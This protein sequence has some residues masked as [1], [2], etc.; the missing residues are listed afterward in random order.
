MSL[1]KLDKRRA[2]LA[3][4]MDLLKC[5]QNIQ[6]RRRFLR[7]LLDV[8]LGLFCGL[9]IELEVGVEW[10]QVKGLVRR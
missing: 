2:L 3:G 7:G 9:R 5:C 4:I 8:P 6:R 1:G 10:G